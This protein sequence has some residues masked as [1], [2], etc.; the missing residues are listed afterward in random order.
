MDRWLFIYPFV[1][2][3]DWVHSLNLAD[4]NGSF[5]KFTI[6]W[7]GA[8]THNANGV[9]FASG[10]QGNTNCD[11]ADVVNNLEAWNRKSHGFYSRTN[12]AVGTRDISASFR[13]PKNGY[14]Y[15][16]GLHPRLADGNCIGYLNWYGKS[17]VT[18]VPNQ[19]VTPVAD[20]LGLFSENQ[21]G[22]QAGMV[23]HYIYKRGVLLTGYE[24][25]PEVGMG[26]GD[27]LGLAMMI[28]SGVR[29]WAFAFSTKHQK[30]LEYPGL[31]GINA[32]FYFFV[33]QF[34][35]ALLRQV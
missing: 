29:N 21:R 3:F 6:T 30:T 28:F 5:S 13:E 7:S 9:T 15:V 33:Q 22:S 14:D 23:S 34:Q 10:G 8:V 24:S 32:E 20:S 19:V 12:S 11:C 26:Y 16:Q 25:S 17:G 35:V 31:P 27:G 2:G 1:G 4:V 18:T